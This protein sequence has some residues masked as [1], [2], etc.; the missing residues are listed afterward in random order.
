MQV[1]IVGCRYVIGRCHHTPYWMTHA[2][3]GVRSA[4]HQRLRI[5]LRLVPQLQPAVA[6]RLVDIERK[7]RRRL[8][9]QKAIE[10]GVEVAGTKWRSK[11]WQHH[12][13]GL[14]SELMAADQGAGTAAAEQHHC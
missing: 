3:E 8:N 2:N 7:R 6:Q 12:Q 13:S 11:R 5:D 10:I 14:L 1:R 9:R 4:R